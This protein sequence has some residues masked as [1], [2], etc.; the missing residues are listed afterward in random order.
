VTALA[1]RWIRLA[2][3]AACLA[4]PF[5]ALAAEVVRMGDLPA[6]TNAGLYIAI[7]KGYFQARGIVVE[8]E[9]FASAGKMVAPLATGQLD[10]A[11]GAPSAGLYNAI[12]G[13]M[14]FRV[15]AD[16]GQLRPGGSFVP[17]IVRKD[18]VDSGR[19]KSVK[20]LKGL[21]VANGAKGIALDYL[22]A[23][24]L[25]QGGLGFDAVEVVYLS[26]PD[27][28]KA[29]ASKAVDAAIAPEPWGVQAEQQ[30]VG[31]RLFLT[32][33]TPAVAT[34]QVGLIM[35]AGKFIK[36]RPKVA[37]DF[38]QAYV[39]GI[40]YYTQRGLK[41]PEVAGILSKHTRVPIETIQATIPFY[42]D[43]GARP[44]VQDLAV[45][46][47]WFHQMGWVKEKVPMERVVDLS[48]L[49]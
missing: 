47:D 40:K 15:V 17:V 2:A 10:V 7:E 43:P 3:L 36:D 29:L 8:T 42:V 9:R 4:L 19:V 38:L 20:D 18:L 32:E 35:Y 1:R 48:F 31:V 5:P 13:G 21:R 11:V 30:K 16:K 39:Q 14:D 46:Q 34:F 45:L 37:R 24:M 25:E 22:L 49:E 44:R 6:I 28:I 33:Q 27:G 41:D 23:K 26:Y 12:A